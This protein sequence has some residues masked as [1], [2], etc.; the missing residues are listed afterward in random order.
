[1]RID[2]RVTIKDSTKEFLL[3]RDGYTI[4][5]GLGSEKIKDIY[6]L[7]AQVFYQELNW[8]PP[9]EFE[10]DNYDRNAVYVTVYEKEVLLGVL[11]I[12][13]ADTDWMLQKEFHLL[14]PK[15]MNKHKNNSGCEVT[16][17]AVRKICRST[18]IGEGLSVA[19]ALYQGLFTYCMLNNCRHV[20]MVVSTIV[21]RALRLSGLPCREM[22]SPIRMSDGVLAVAACL[23]WNLFVEQNS[24]HRPQLLANYIDTL[25]QVQTNQAEQLEQVV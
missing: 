2:K 13:G 11:R 21:L 4:Q 23:D 22:A 19:D 15:D 3:E 24:L 20:Y 8:V 17:L 1:M 10:T 9:T 18:K 14:A 16:R 12:L 7:R 6:R 25:K 5:C